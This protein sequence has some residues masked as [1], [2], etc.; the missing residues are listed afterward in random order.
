MEVPLF[1]I[2]L[3]LID[4]LLPNP[5][6][7][8]VLKGW[9]FSEV[10]EHI[11][12]PALFLLTA[13]LF[14]F[15][16][17]VVIPIIIFYIYGRVLGEAKTGKDWMKVLLIYIGFIFMLYFPTMVLALGEYVAPM[18]IMFVT[19]VVFISIWGISKVKSWYPNKL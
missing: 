7:H 6:K 19:S 3:A 11:C 18:W 1:I 15:L 12:L 10:L 14:T 13:M 2:S 9:A 16:R 17:L 8:G 5:K 4:M